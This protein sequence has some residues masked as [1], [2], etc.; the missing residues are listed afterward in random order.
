MT[1]GVSGLKNIQ[2]TFIDFEE[3]IAIGFHKKTKK[4]Y[5]SRD[6]GTTWHKM[7]PKKVICNES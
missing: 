3:E 5:Y 2:I 6:N 4:W 1:L 7:K